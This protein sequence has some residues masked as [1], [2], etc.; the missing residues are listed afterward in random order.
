MVG[1]FVPF[2]E[3]LPQ[4]A[5]TGK[6]I[7]PDDNNFP[8]LNGVTVPIKLIW[9]SDRA[10]SPI[11][12]TLRDGP[13]QYLEWYVHAD[14][15]HSTTTMMRL[16]RGGPL[17]ATGL[18]RAPIQPVHPSGMLRGETLQANRIKLSKTGKSAKTDM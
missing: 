15:S 16:R 17:E 12:G 13:P 3:A 6:I 10:Y 1:S 18:V 5:T 2:S 7:Y 14:G 4:T 11:V 8:A 9:T